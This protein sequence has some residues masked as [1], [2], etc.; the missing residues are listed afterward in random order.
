MSRLVHLTELK[1]RTLKQAR[2]QTTL[3]CTL[4]SLYV[5]VCCLHKKVSRPK[6]DSSK[7]EDDFELVMLDRRGFHGIIQDDRTLPGVGGDPTVCI[8]ILKQWLHR[9]LREMSTCQ[10]TSCSW[11]TLSVL[12][13]QSGK[14][15]RLVHIGQAVAPDEETGAGAV[16]RKGVSGCC[17]ST[18]LVFLDNFC[19]PL[20]RTVQVPLSLTLL[21][22]SVDVYSVTE[23]LTQDPSLVLHLKTTGR[24]S[25][26]PHFTLRVRGDPDAIVCAIYSVGS[27]L[28]SEST[29]LAWIPLNSLLCAVRLTDPIKINAGRCRFHQDLSGPFHS[30]RKTDTI[31]LVHIICFQVGQQSSEAAQPNDSLAGF[32]Q[33][34]HWSNPAGLSGKSKTTQPSTTKFCV[35]YRPSSTTRC[36]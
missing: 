36:L 1:I 9:A 3:A 25:D 20:T 22:L 14:D 35:R 7:S 4:D 30:K 17:F 11:I 18:S 29:F 8:V 2:Q 16:G 13:T 6:N 21:S 19:G 5:D 33:M 31:I 27:A 32:H 26:V 28:S 15:D 34:D 23:T 12:D 10:V 24:N